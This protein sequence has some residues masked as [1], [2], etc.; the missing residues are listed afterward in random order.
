MN[1]IAAA[2]RAAMALAGL[3]G[4]TLAWV[5]NSHNETGFIV[6]RRVGRGPFQEI[7]R[8]PANVQGYVDRTA[9]RKARLMYRVK[10]YNAA[11][12]S[13]YTPARGRVD[14]SA[15]KGTRVRAGS[16]RLNAK[17]Q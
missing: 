14:G 2:I 11:G 5:D 4:T 1:M 15:I 7:A 3:P 17:R 13:E 9:P 12:E 6:E 10:A 16:M 8:L